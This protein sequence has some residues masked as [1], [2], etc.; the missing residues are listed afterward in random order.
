V[1]T[2]PVL[3][4]ETVDYQG[5]Q[6]VA[7]IIPYLSGV[8][9]LA[10]ICLSLSHGDPD[11]AASVGRWWEEFQALPQEQRPFDPSVYVYTEAEQSLLDQALAIYQQRQDH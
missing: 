6:C 1:R 5:V 10:T 7:D 9:K 3:S 11:I 2:N 4:R 8:S